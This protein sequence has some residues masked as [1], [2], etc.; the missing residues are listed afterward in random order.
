MNKNYEIEIEISN[1]KVTATVHGVSG[2][3][4]SDLSKWLDSL[5]TVEKDEK[6][7]DFQ[8]TATVSSGAAVRG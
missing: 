2:P 5:G 3:K 1:G 7:L 8:K 6:T 4:C